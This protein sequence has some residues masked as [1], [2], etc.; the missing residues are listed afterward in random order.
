MR[1]ER[2]C[3]SQ[4]WRMHFYPSHTPSTNSLQAESMCR[5]TVQGQASFNRSV[6]LIE[7]ATTPGNLSPQ[8][9]LL[10]PVIVAIVKTVKI[11]SN[12]SGDPRILHGGC[13]RINGNN[14]YPRPHSTEDTR[15]FNL[16]TAF[17][18]VVAHRHRFW[19]NFLET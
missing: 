8:D 11:R 18:Y 13:R 19:W 3:A 14:C 9:H 6:S 17:L 15:T 1:D 2:N 5:S 10:E 16:R 4:G 12:D 7:E